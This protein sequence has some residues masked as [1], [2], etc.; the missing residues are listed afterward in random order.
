M[1]IN[2]DF[3]KNNLWLKGTYK[4]AVVRIYKTTDC[5][6]YDWYNA[7]FEYNTIVYNND[8]WLATPEAVA[9]RVYDL[10]DALIKLKIK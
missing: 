7:G 8:N 1:S 4:D 6:G 5:E 2:K 10:I 3:F 9:N